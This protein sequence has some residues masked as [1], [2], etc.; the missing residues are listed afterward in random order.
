MANATKLTNHDEDPN[1]DPEGTKPSRFH[2]LEAFAKTCYKHQV[3]VEDFA[4]LFGDDDPGALTEHLAETN[5]N[6]LPYATHRDGCES[7]VIAAKANEAIL[8]GKRVE[9]SASEY[10]L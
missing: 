7:V 8:T 10:N 9:W 1:K 4:A 5:K 2:A 6:K 3:A